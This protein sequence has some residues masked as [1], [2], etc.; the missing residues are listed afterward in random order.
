MIKFI[1]LHC[2]ILGSQTFLICKM[3]CKTLKLIWKLL[4]SNLFFN[5]SGL[6]FLCVVWTKY[7]VHCS[8][9]DLIGLVYLCVHF[10]YIWCGVLNIFGLVNLCVHSWYIWCGVLNIFGLV[11][12]CVHAWVG[13]LLVYCWTKL[14]SFLFKGSKHLRKFLFKKS[15]CE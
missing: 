7:N 6:G 1:T 13:N 12:M 14:Q 5:T 15:E 11:Y 3:I 10:W 4:N 9:L 2:F 8:L